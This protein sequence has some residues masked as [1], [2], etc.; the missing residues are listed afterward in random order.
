MRD[1]S[2]TIGQTVYQR[3]LGKESM[4]EKMSRGA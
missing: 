4:Y 3:E 1:I 2:Q